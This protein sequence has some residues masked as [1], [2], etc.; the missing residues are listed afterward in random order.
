LHAVGAIIFIC[1]AIR[2]LN[3]GKCFSDVMIELGDLLESGVQ[4]SEG[5]HHPN[6]RAQSS[7]PRSTY[8]HSML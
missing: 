8:R 4:A 2:A 6:C 1:Y 7:H 5:T 3:D